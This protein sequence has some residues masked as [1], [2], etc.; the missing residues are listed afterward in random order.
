MVD[1]D[2]IT[3]WY[4]L[5]RDNVGCTEYREPTNCR[6]RRTERRRAYSRLVLAR[7][8]AAKC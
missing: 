7:V 5:L 2:V 1:Y 4:L 6:V 8:S 3:P